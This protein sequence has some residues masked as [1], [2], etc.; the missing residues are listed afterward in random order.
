M[1][2]KIVQII[3]L[4]YYHYCSSSIISQEK[5]SLSL[6]IIALFNWLLHKEYRLKKEREKKVC[7]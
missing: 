6:Y 7:I 1:Q 2:V 3:G 5:V 4:K